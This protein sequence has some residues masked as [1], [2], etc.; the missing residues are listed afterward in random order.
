[1]EDYYVVKCVGVI[2]AVGNVPPVGR[3]LAGFD[4]NLI[5]QPDCEGLSTWASVRSLAVRFAT[6]DQ[7]QD[8]IDSVPDDHPVRANGTANRLLDRYRLVIEHVEP[9]VPKPRMSLLG[10]MALDGTI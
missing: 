2:G 9:E 4:P 1:M 10:E 5:P 8:C 3:W 6:R 7:A